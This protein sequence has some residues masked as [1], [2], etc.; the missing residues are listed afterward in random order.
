MSTYEK[1]RSEYDKRKHKAELRGWK[2]PP[3]GSHT[4]QENWWVA[5]MSYWD[6]MGIYEQDQSG[7]RPVIP[8]R[9]G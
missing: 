4:D 5:W 2:V 6:Q 1:M 7:G 8:H 9:S 3:E